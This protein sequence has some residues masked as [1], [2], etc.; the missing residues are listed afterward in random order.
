MI[1]PKDSFSSLDILALADELRAVGKAWFDK[2][3][4]LPQGGFLFTLR[5][6]AQG[7]RWLK[8]LPGRCLALLAQEV[9]HLPEPGPFVQS[10]RKLLSGLPLA[11]VEQPG[12]ERYLELAFSRSLEES[13]RLLVLELFGEGNALV[14][15]EGVLAAVAHSRIW[16]HRAVRPGEKYARPPERKNPLKLTAADVLPILLRSKTSVVTTLAARLSLGGSVAEEVVAR[17]GADPILPASLATEAMATAVVNA[18]SQMVFEIGTGPRGYLYREGDMLV[19][20]TPYSSVRLNARPGVTSEVLPTF[21]EGVERHFSALSPVRTVSEVAED[22]ERERLERLKAQQLS[23][24]AALETMAKELKETADSILS[25]YAE[26]EEKVRVLLDKIPD[27]PEVEIEVKGRKVK[28]AAKKVPRQSAQQFYDEAKRQTPRLEGA[29]RALQDTEA[30]LTVLAKKGAAAT[31]A[32]TKGGRP[33]RKKHF[34]FEKAPRWFLS[35][36]G[37]PIV[38]GKDARTNDWVVKRYL[39]EGDRYIHAD[40]HGAPSVIVKVG[41]GPAPSEPALEQAGAWS[42]SYSKAWRAAHASADAYWVLGDQVSKAGK[43]G[44]YVPVGSWVIHGTKHFLRDL[45]VALAIGEA[46]YEGET[47]LFAAP[48]SAFEREGARVLWRLSPG[49]EKER[50]TV[51]R[52]LSKELGVSIETVQSMLPGG[53]VR[54]ERA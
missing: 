52:T 13:P 47:L 11:Q 40:V 37:V 15:R 9:P 28:M 27:T 2:A 12:G 49:D 48:P 21:S 19:D 31:Q 8:V 10:V 38:G 39:K 42:V 24:I 33:A 29:K 3:Y 6:E 41:E 36:S 50:R 22:K 51:E 44:E 4:D 1:Q 53:G 18:L 17:I 35:S 46:T 7:K 25:N 45:P 14:V 43:S 16:A 30:A 5:T 34:W 26:V 23:G 20:V 32:P 54:A